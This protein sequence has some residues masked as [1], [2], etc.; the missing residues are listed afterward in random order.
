MILK[1]QRLATHGSFKDAVADVVRAAA[2]A[3]EGEML[4]VLV[5]L[6][7]GQLEGNPQHVVGLVLPLVLVLGPE[8]RGVQTWRTSGTSRHIS[9]S[10]LHKCTCVCVCMRKISQFTSINRQRGRCFELLLGCCEIRHDHVSILVCLSCQRA[11]KQ[12]S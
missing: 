1:G 8:L 2:R 10:Y 12:E 4:A 6:L 3:G 7:V 5:A 9:P 11:V